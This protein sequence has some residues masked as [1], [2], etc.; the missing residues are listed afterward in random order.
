MIFA[1]NKFIFGT[2]FRNHIETSFNIGVLLQCDF[3]YIFKVFANKTYML[4]LTYN[5]T[6]CV[7]GAGSQLWRILTIYLTAKYFK[8]GYIHTPIAYM[9]Y[10]GLEALEKN[11]GD[12]SQVA[13]YNSLFTFPSDTFTGTFD[14]EHAVGHLT[15]ELLQ[16]AY[17]MPKNILLKISWCTELVT[18]KLYDSLI[19][20]LEKPFLPWL[21]TVYNLPVII[22][23]H[24]RRGELYIV[25]SDRMLPNS[26]YIEI[27]QGLEV[28]LNEFNIP[29]EFHLYTEVAKKDIVVTP[30]HHGICN[31]L[32]SNVTISPSFYKVEELNCVKNIKF[33][34]NT[35]PVQ[36]IQSL[37]NSHFLITSRSC[38]SYVPA[39]LKNYG[40]A[41]S[42]VQEDSRVDRFMIVNTKEDIYN[43]KV[44]IL[45]TL[46]KTIV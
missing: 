30:T 42:C 9:S 3:N 35:C 27:M 39:A 29:H 41:F 32:S 25:A 5:N 15:L 24:V 1:E 37:A 31:Q 14:E 12:Q 19:L 26:Y 13:Q 4:Y 10:C 38:F 43:N 20:N 16:I 8:L 6:I 2:Y 45:S 36:A 44:K 18:N 23:V 28:I 7:D 33:F 21:K 22:A 34:I 40:L 17:N 46:L 11:D